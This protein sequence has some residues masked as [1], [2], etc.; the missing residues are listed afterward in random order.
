M[1]DLFEQID[2]IFTT[3][4]RSEKLAAP[5]ADDDIKAIS[6][7]F[8]FELP[9]TVKNLYRW[10]NGIEEFIPAYDFIALEDA[11]FK[12]E[13]L[14]E[15]SKFLED[16][17]DSPFY[18]D[19]YLPILQHQDTYLVVDCD[20]T[21][22]PSIYQIW[23]EGDDNF[24]YYESLE[25]MFRV[26]VDA[27]WCRAFYQEDDFLYDNPVLFEKVRNKYL[28]AVQLAEKEKKWESLAREA[29]AL[30][31]SSSANRKYFFS[32]LY[33]PYDER[34]I[35]YL[36]KLLNDPDPEVLSSAAFGLGQLR[37][38]ESLPD[39]VKLLKHPAERVRNLSVCAIAEMISPDDVLLLQPLLELLKDSSSLVRLGAV[40][41]L[42]NLRNPEAVEPVIACLRTRS[43]GLILKAVKALQKIGGAKALDAL[44]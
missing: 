8:P 3:L 24:M 10:H 38:R 5:L 6:Y 15:T 1:Q 14:I 25:Q 29:D 33:Y 11:I 43:S 37:S 2:K 41:A 18:K 28:S 32:T 23:V 42:G 30:L 20:P 31:Q 4:E 35:P 17:R 34:A 21:A 27:Y 16:G 12:Y 39:L 22:E 9:D 13:G 36:Q 40:E 7:F 19:T 44:R 26:F